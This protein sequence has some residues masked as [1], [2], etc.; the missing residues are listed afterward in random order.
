MYVTDLQYFCALTSMLSVGF[1][2]GMVVSQ[3]R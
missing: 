3:W 2:L 1:A